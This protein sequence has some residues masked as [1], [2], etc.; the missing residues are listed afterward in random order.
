MTDTYIDPIDYLYLCLND[1]K[2]QELTKGYGLEKWNCFL[3]LDIL[4]RNPVDL[5]N[6]DKKYTYSNYENV[7][8]ISIT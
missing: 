3:I 6:Y 4:K 2:N 5:S 7:Y 1:K 8:R